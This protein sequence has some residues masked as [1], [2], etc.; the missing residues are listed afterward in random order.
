MTGSI[1]LPAVELVEALKKGGVGDQLATDTGFHYEQLEANL[2][3]AEQDVERALS[4]RNKALIEAGN[5]DKH[6][7]TCRGA[8]IKE[9]IV[10]V[11]APLEI[12]TLTKSSLR[13]PGI[14]LPAIHWNSQFLLCKGCGWNDKPVPPEKGWLARLFA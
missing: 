8:L 9:L 12:T 14:D 13:F 5:P 2:Q 10:T 7:P 11:H 4:A 3:E 6:C 1:V